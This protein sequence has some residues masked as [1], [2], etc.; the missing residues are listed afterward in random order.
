VPD[1][2]SYSDEDL[3][4][5]AA[6]QQVA[7]KVDLSK[8]SDA[9][10]QAL[11]GGK[12]AEKK[13]YAL[14]DVPS[15]ALGNVS[16][17]GAQ[18]LDSLI[19]PFIHPV[20]TATNLA[21]LA[22]SSTLTPAARVLEPAARLLLSD[23]QKKKLSE[24]LTDIETPKSAMGE[25]F[26]ERYG[27]WENVKRTMAEDPVGFLSDASTL[28]SG[29]AGLLA[30]TP[31]IG[32][33]MATVSKVADVVNPANVVTRAPLY[34]ASKAGGLLAD[35]SGTLTGAGG[36]ALRDAATV[37]EGFLRNPEQSQVFLGHLNGTRPASELADLGKSAIAKMEAEKKVAYRNEMARLGL[38][39]EVIPS[40]KPID[41]AVDDARD[42]TMSRAPGKTTGPI[43]DQEA[44]NVRLQAQKLID[45]WKNKQDW[46]GTG[47]QGDPWRLYHQTAAGVDELK[48][49]IGKLDANGAQAQKVRA[50]IYDAVENQITQQAP[51]YAEIM[52]DYHTAS[53]ANDQLERMFSLG[54]N[55]MES[56]GIGKLQR[57]ARHNV[58]SNYKAMEEGF[59]KLAEYEPNLVAARAGQQLASGSPR[60]VTST[61]LRKI[62]YG[63]T[64][65]E[66]LQGLLHGGQIPLTP[67]QLA[68]SGAAGLG[69]WAATSPSLAARAARLS[70]QF[71]TPY[72][73]AGEA[74]RGAGVDP[75]KATAYTGNMLSNTYGSPAEQGPV[76]RLWSDIMR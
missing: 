38:E 14:S 28:I 48:K 36:Q 68:I 24:I 31:V 6:G 2:S 15:T 46:V 17:S 44:E 39:D 53:R 41:Q 67:A 45:D 71:R 57:S 74:M 69:A 8:M 7:P 12:S 1:L 18:F 75:A 47:Q 72:R 30:K 60:G 34:A 65:T 27:G 55:A 16:K 64:A 32:K 63:A 35:V 25:F 62:G 59:Q 9:E 19:Q 23:E 29:G 58:T 70:G 61:A 73:A 52:K 4:R 3:Q 21:K 56:T 40:W 43:M 26:K 22:A 66:V 42:I 51:K 37:S 33:T 54:E 5:I 49:A 11:A 13:N 76:D 10:L 50:D 20:D